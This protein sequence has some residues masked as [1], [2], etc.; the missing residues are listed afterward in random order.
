MKTMKQ[1]YENLIKGEEN[2]SFKIVGDSCC[3]FTED[4]KEKSYI[5]N[6]PLTIEVG[7]YKI[8][9]DDSFNQRE[10]LDKVSEY[11]GCP[12][13]A[14]PSPEF[15]K[16]AYQ[17][18]D[19]VYVV[20][21]SSKLSGSYNSARVAADLYKEE[22]PNANVHVFDS[23]GAASKQFLLVQEIEKLAS[24]G[25]PFSKV[26]EEVEKVNKGQEILFVLGTIEILRKN[27]RL[28]LVKATIAEVL[29]IKPLL[30]GEHGEIKHVAQGRGVKKALEKLVD[31]VGTL[32]KNYSERK[33][34]ISHCDC[35]ERA[36]ELGETL[37]KRYHFKELQVIEARGITS[38]YAADGGVIVSF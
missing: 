38:L 33:L 5:I 20:T 22:N 8:I 32:E 34:M 27:G 25:L 11:S 19:D 30:C 26:V 14:C 6:I 31:H 28:P 12:R 23:E 9:D 15:Y 7:D 17:G 3:D 29:N 1:G 16:E 4:Y 13:S 10:F 24:E 36:K 21:L 35:Y 2:M 37:L 18:V